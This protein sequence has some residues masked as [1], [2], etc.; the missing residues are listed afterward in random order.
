MLKWGVKMPKENK[1]VYQK[2]NKIFD[3][4]YCKIAKFQSHFK[5]LLKFCSENN[6]T[7]HKYRVLSWFSM[8]KDY[9]GRITDKRCVDAKEKEVLLNNAIA[10]FEND[11]IDDLLKDKVGRLKVFESLKFGE[12]END[13]QAINVNIANFDLENKD[14]MRL[15]DI[16][17]EEV[18]NGVN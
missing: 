8:N 7:P 16:T 3:W 14:Y 10:N 17:L 15:K 1:K 4:R 5:K 6:K 11:L 12:A 2:W 13:K 9:Q 18:K